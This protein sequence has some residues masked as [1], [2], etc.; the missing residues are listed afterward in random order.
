MEGTHIH[1]PI[2]LEEEIEL[3]HKICERQYRACSKNADAKDKNLKE[4]MSWFRDTS[5]DEVH[6]ILEWD[7]RLQ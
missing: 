2:A 6:E 5:T 7:T 3:F 1:K 4:I